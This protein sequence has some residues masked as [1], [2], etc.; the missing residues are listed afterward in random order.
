M[1]EEGNGGLWSCWWMKGE[2]W[3]R[4]VMMLGIVE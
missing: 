4:W 2:V 3:G 1:V